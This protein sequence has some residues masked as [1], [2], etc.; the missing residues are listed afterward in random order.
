[1]NVAEYRAAPG[2]SYSG[3]KAYLKSPLHGLKQTSPSESAAM[4]F[5]TGVDMVLKGEQASV[6]VAPF[7]D[8][9]TKE[10]KA[11]K[12]ANIGSFIVSAN[13]AASIG[14]CAEAVNNHPAV[15]ELN[16][17]YMASDPKLFGEI[18]GIK[19][20]G[21]P[22][23]AFGGMIVDLKT[24]SGGVDATS[25]A[26]T[27]DNFH[28]DMQAAMYVELVRQSGEENPQF[29]WVAVESDNP[30][31]VAVYAATPRIIEVGRAKL[32]AALRNV[33]MAQAG[34]RHGTSTLLRELDM[35]QWYGKGWSE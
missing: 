24:T 31:D 11:W 3:L 25:F 28:Y 7:D 15:R 12:E 9:R 14:A 34:A 26:R 4:R 1:M 21:M 33:K 27:V 17:N 29:Y 22:D 19:V 13:D 8:F 35:P 30:Y 6:V 16:L 23:W 5:G 20:K 10:A 32:N 18:D 2:Y